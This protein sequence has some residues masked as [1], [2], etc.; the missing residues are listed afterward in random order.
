MRPLVIIAGDSRLKHF[1]HIAGNDSANFLYDQKIIFQPGAK[2]ADISPIL[3]DFIKSIE[4]DRLVVVKIAIGIN[5]L[6]KKRYNRHG[7]FE[8]VLSDTSRRAILDAFSA[9]SN[10]IKPVHQK[11]VVTFCRI[12]IC[13]FLKYNNLLYSK[14]RTIHRTLSDAYLIKLTDQLIEKIVKI[15]QEIGISNSLEQLGITP[16]TASIDSN[17]LICCPGKKPRLCPSTMYDGLHP[18]D[19]CAE[20]WYRN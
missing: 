19:K 8:L 18:T 9:L 20:R 10:D 6:T 15:N 2:I 5:N 17:S 16:H 13:N 12:P 7:E 1:P 4:T 3:V 11:S 14:Q